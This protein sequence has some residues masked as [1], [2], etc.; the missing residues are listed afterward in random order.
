MPDAQNPYQTQVAAVATYYRLTYDLLEATRPE[1]AGQLGITNE[2]GMVCL[3]YNHERFVIKEP[4]AA[5]SFTL[6]SGSGENVALDDFA[7][8]TPSP[9]VLI[10]Y[11][12]QQCPMCLEQ[13]SAYNVAYGQFKAAGIEVVAISP[14]SPASLSRVQQNYQFPLLSDADGSVSSSYG[15]V[16]ENGNA[17][18]GVAVVDQGGELFWLAV[19]DLPFMSVG[20]VYAVAF[21]RYNQPKE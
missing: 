15:I 8:D 21:N 6:S 3:E 19:T 14:D 5:S 11:S 1:S 20:D 12:G 4:V 2:L 16:D 13:L 7:G 18:H 17:S 10:F 9:V